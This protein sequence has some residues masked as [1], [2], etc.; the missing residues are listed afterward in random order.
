MSKK[1]AFGTLTDRSLAEFADRIHKRGFLDTL[2][3]RAPAF[4]NFA[5]GIT[6]QLPVSPDP[7][8]PVPEIAPGLGPI[9][10]TLKLGFKTG[11]FQKFARRERVEGLFA[12][13]FDAKYFDKLQ[14]RYQSALS[15]EATRIL[16]RL[17]CRLTKRLS[18]A[19][20]EREMRDL[21]NGIGNE[22][23]PPR[24]I[25]RDVFNELAIRFLGN[26]APL[27][28]YQH[29][30]TVNT[31][32]VDDREGREFLQR[33]GRALQYRPKEMFDEKDWVIMLLWDEMPRGIP[34]PGNF[35]D[36]LINNYD[37]VTG[38]FIETLMRADGTPLQFE[39][40]WDLLPQAGGV[41]FTAGIADEEHGLFGI[42]TEDEERPS[43]RR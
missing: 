31:D 18:S 23:W 7:L 30:I 11:Q 2:V 20:Y 5:L 38:A 15:L 4:S 1:H 27:W 17:Q 13:F 36:G 26:G 37:P 9:G 32:R 41:F 33:L 3:R 29:I 35:G 22:G 28:L 14:R 39:G 42:I 16:R 19:D 43:A 34:R 10:P 21:A 40:L 25:F 12:E 24:K 8:V 6:K